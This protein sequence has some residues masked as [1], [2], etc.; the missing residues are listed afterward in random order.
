MV[1]VAGASKDRATPRTV[2]AVYPLESRI[3]IEG[4]N[5]VTK[6]LKPNAQNPTGSIIKQEAPLHISNVMLWDAKAGA[7]TRVRRERSE[8]GFTRIS[9]KSGVEIK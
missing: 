8:A 6:H 9:K 4:A 7:P 2:L 3:L 1:I 5:M